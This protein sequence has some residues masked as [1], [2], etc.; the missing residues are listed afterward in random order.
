M[1]PF[2]T[3]LRFKFKCLFFKLLY[4]ENCHPK[5]VADVYLNMY[6]LEVYETKLFVYIFLIFNRENQNNQIFPITRIFFY[7][8]TFFPVLFLI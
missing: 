6:A 3:I 1:C 4:P 7:L 5:N 8:T 2:S